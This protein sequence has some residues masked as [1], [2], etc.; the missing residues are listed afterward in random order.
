MGAIATSPGRDVKCGAVTAAQAGMRPML[1]A[2]TLVVLLDVATTPMALSWG[3][4]G[5]ESKPGSEVSLGM[6]DVLFALLVAGLMPRWGAV[7]RYLRTMPYLRI[8]LLYVALVC[9]AYLVAPTNQQYLDGVLGVGYQLYRYCCKWPLAYVTIGIFARSLMAYGALPLAIT[10]AADY[11]A[12]LAIDQGYGGLRA[13]GPF[14]QPN[15]LGA[16]LLVPLFIAGSFSLIEKDFRLRSIYLISALL[17][18]R[19]FMFTESRGAWIAFA[20]GTLVAAALLIRSVRGRRIVAVASAC[21]LGL[22]LLVPLIKPNFVQTGFAQRLF[23][24]RDPTEVGTLEWRQERWQNFLQI[25]F[26]YSRLGD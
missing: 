21:I 16:F 25:V 3:V 20:A 7:V 11:A 6:S 5:D 23:S 17:Q 12:V 2:L 8:W 9:V 18:V 14:G 4:G 19:A 10:A 1:A 26:D 13:A 22:V 15:E 24:L